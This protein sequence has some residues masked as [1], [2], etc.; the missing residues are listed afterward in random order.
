[1]RILLAAGTVTDRLPDWRPGT[2][3]VDVPLPS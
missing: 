1:M 2:L 3:I